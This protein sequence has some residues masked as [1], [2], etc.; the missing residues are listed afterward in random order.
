VLFLLRA[1]YRRHNVYCL[2]VD[3]DTGPAFIN[4]VRSVA[5]C[6]PNVF[7]STKLESI[8]YAGFSRFLAD[9]NCMQDL[10]AHPVGWKY[11]HNL[12]GQQFP[13]RTNLEIVNILKIY[14]GANDILG[15]PGKKSLPRRYKNKHRIVYNNIT[16][17]HVIVEAVGKK[18]PPPHDFKIV[19]GSAYGS[20]SR[21]FVEFLLTNEKVRDLIE[22]SK[23]V[24]SPDEYVFATV[25]HTRVI[26]VPGGYKGVPDQKRFLASFTAWENETPCASM[27]VRWICIFTTADLPMLLERK[28]LFA[29]K[30]YIDHYPA[31]LHCLDQLLYNLTVQGITRDLDFYRTVSFVR[32]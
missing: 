26:D 30:F 21:A 8:V 14:N 27:F 17:K 3:L 32:S 25:H 5:A 19:K 12:P 9:I 13:L 28:E 6:L 1:I 18:S 11:L 7:L 10:I 15:L 24:E 16:G 22:W 23:D 29:N 2:T 31:T 4:A 20:Y